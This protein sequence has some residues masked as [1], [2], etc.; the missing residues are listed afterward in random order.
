MQVS[1]RESADDLLTPAEV[2][3][4]LRVTVD[5]LAK[6]RCQ[7][8]GPEFRKHGRPV[9]YR[10]GDVVTWS[11]SRTASSTAQTSGYRPGGG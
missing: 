4:I 11:A 1:D 8:F 7:G 2:A 3:E 5:T 10:R 9:F 6:W